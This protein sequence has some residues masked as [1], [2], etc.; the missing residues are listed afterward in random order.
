[1]KKKTYLVAVLV[2]GILAACSESSSDWNENNS[3][4][5]RGKLVRQIEV[6]DHDYSTSVPSEIMDFYY[7]NTNR[8]TSICFNGNG[9][10]F[11]RPQGIQ[12]F[13][14]LN[15]NKMTLSWRPANSTQVPMPGDGEGYGMG[16]GILN[17]RRM[18]SEE[19]FEE[20]ESSMA[21]GEYKD[22]ISYYFY[23]EQGQTLLEKREGR[24]ETSRTWTWENGNVVN[25]YG[26]NDK[27]YTYTEYENKVNIHLN[28]LFT[29]TYG[30]DMYAISLCGYIGKKDNNLIATLK[31]NSGTVVYSYE[32]DTAGYPIQIDF[33]KKYTAFIYYTK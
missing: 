25:G 19:C 29:Q 11:I 8:V 6:Y 22:G 21:S 2:F 1:M 24:Y 32:L 14:D 28:R 20:T 17:E 4:G 9:P 27:G 5:G 13:Y 10:T 16:Y 7:D 26:G 30:E 18:L 23:D 12:L 31:E 33:G 15:G 3:T